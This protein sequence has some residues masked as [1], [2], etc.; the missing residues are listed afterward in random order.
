MLMSQNYKT[1]LHIN[2]NSPVVPV[3]THLYHYHMK[4]LMS[5]IFNLDRLL[6]KTKITPQRPSIYLVSHLYDQKYAGQ[7]LENLYF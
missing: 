5:E 6:R 7:E 1:L 4:I 3:F 2:S